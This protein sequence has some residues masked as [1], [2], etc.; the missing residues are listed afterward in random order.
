M[1]F[2]GVLLAFLVVSACSSTPKRDYK[3][4]EIPEVINKDPQKNLSAE[5]VKYDISQAIYALETAYSGKSFLPS[6]EYQALIRNLKEIH[7]PISVQYFC[8]KIDGYM[9]S[10]SD[11][12]LG[13]KFNNNA[14]FKSPNIREPKVGNNFYAKKN[15]IP[16]DI[17]LTGKNKANALLISITNF[18]SSTSPFWNGFLEKIKKSLP[19]SELI[20]ID[21]RG[22][23]G[24]D[25]TKGFELASL[26][27]G[28]ELKE[29]K[30]KQW[31]NPSPEAQQILLNTFDYWARIEQEEGRKVAPYILDLKKQH[32]DSRNEAIKNR[33]L[34]PGEEEKKSEGQDF[35]YEKSIQKPIYILVDASCASSCESTTDFFEYNPFVKTVGEKTAG[36]IHFGN[37]GAVFLKNSGI[38]LQMATAYNSYK[39]GRFIEKAGIKPKIPVPAGKDALSYAWK[40]FFQTKRITKSR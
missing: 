9:D 5:E 23:G 20:I 38:K 7:G 3:F 17:K 6:G 39:D 13:A 25:D 21:M 16:W 40:D 19:L 35:D 24:G 22:N 37:N 4:I 34:L 2:F 29:P 28:A 26:L 14:C 18:P 33:G 36:Y 30:S 27:S 1:R 31:R 15:E 12:H 11:N 8:E 10:V 32:I